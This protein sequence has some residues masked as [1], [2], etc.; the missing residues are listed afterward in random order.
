MEKKART[1]GGRPSQTSPEKHASARPLTFWAPGATQSNT[2]TKVVNR[3][4]A[5]IAHRRYA[6]PLA[7]QERLSLIHI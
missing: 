4:Y 1:L 6:R 3:R 2:T 7:A 5:E